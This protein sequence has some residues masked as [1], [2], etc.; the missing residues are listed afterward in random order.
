MTEATVK[1]NYAGH[2]EVC[3]ESPTVVVVAEGQEDDLGLCGPCCF[4]TARALDPDN[5]ESLGDDE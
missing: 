3:G 2:C 5:W 4:G 1:P